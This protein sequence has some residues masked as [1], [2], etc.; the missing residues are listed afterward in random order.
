MMDGWDTEWNDDASEATEWTPLTLF[1]KQARAIELLMDPSGPNQVALSGAI[2]FGKTWAAIVW[3][4]KLALGW[5]GITGCVCRSTFVDLDRWF[6][7]EFHAVFHAI[8][9]P[10]VA[11]PYDYIG[12][13]IGAFKFH[14]GST[15]H[16]IGANTGRDEGLNK[17]HGSDLSFGV[18]EEVQQMLDF[19][20]VLSKVTQRLSQAGKFGLKPA[21]LV[22]G[23]PAPREH[24]LFRLF[25]DPHKK[26]TLPDF[27]AFIQGYTSD[28]TSLSPE[29]H[30]LQRTALS[31]AEYQV[32]YLGNWE[33]V[34]TT[35]D[36]FRHDALRTVFRQSDT[37][38][39]RSFITIDPATDHGQDTTVICVWSDW[40]CHTIVQQHQADPEWIVD[41][42]KALQRA[43]RVSVDHTIIDHGGI[44]YAIGK[45][46]GWK[47][48]DAGTRALNGEP[49]FNL[50]SQLY[51]R[52]ADR[53]NTGVC[54][55][56]VTDGKLQSMIVEELSAH[57]S[58]NQFTDARNR[59]LGKEQVKQ[60]IKRSPD[61]SDA[62]SYRA[63]FDY[64]NDDF[65][66]DWA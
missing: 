54:S 20:Q 35:G 17:L 36:V 63:Y 30:E 32:N 59:I 12:G 21:V 1:P 31:E 25:Y 58:V 48:Y 28:N 42:V 23:N 22:T 9:G 55:I 62:L 56:G 13:H 60:K 15:I 53:I 2:R 51:F 52:L 43:Y 24:D 45:T 57:K 3:C 37:Y 61:I 11:R 10:D 39:D 27:R 7:P 41:K 44:G 6:V 65:D 66:I 8:Y 46:E 38:G 29:W 5:P 4:L 33:Y 16:L 50:K 40:H 26:G 34:T 49:Y 47:T 64:V 14:N 18:L 19:E